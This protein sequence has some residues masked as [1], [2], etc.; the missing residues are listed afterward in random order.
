MVSKA[1]R[2]YAKALLITAVEQKILEEIREDM[3]LIHETIANSSELSLFLRSPIIRS[4]VKK[5]SLE[6][7]F[8]DKI[9]QLTSNLISVL[10]EK[11]R[12][13]LLFG[14]SNGFTELYN[15]HHNIIEVEVETAF[16]LKDVQESDLKKELEALTGKTINMRTKKNER[17]IG[18]LTVRIEDTVYDGSAKYKLNQ[19]KRKF[20]TAVE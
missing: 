8:F 7:I 4:N 6:K 3:R 11:G 1:A 2:R 20:T 18:G 14:I 19:L 15:R 17:L 10:S 5:S 13:N 16:D 9:H 12:E